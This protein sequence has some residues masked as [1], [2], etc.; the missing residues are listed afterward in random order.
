MVF[1][2]CLF[3]FVLG[4]GFFCWVFVVGGGDLVC[5]A[6]GGFFAMSWPYSFTLQ[7]KILT[8]YNL[9]LRCWDETNRYGLLKQNLLYTEKAK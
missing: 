8:H 4:L 3:C 6:F 7:K 2:V 9:V 5:F 1:L